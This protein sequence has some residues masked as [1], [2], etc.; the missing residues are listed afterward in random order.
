[1]GDNIKDKLK[2]GKLNED[3]TDVP[4]KKWILLELKLAKIFKRKEIVIPKS[5][6]KIVQ[7]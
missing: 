4:I 3:S 2:S 7:P 6:A 5:K 1:M